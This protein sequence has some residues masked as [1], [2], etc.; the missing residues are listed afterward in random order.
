MVD[1]GIWAKKVVRYLHNEAGGIE[2]MGFIEQDA[3]NFIQAHKRNMIS[4]GDSQTLI[5]HFMHLQSENSNFFH[6]FQ[7]N[8][9]GR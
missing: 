9:D 1:V 8:E 2:N 6:S 4:G 5:N 3:H 7:V